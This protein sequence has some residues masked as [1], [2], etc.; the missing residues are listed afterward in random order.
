MEADVHSTDQQLLL[1]KT[2]LLLETR[3]AVEQSPSES[4][5]AESYGSQI[6]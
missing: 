4:S 1:L 5:S 6:K 3:D 2:K